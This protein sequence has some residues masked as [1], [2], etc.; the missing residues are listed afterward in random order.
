MQIKK[1][2]KRCQSNHLFQGLIYVFCTYLCVK[3][4]LIGVRACEHSLNT[5]KVTA[6]MAVRESH[7]PISRH[8]SDRFRSSSFQPH[9]PSKNDLADKELAKS[10]KAFVASNQKD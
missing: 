2:S 4:K 7:V 8:P 5:A 6:C 10:T 9:T 1:W 3:T